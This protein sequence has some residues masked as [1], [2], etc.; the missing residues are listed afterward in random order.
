V[1]ET[2]T[3]DKSV[4]DDMDFESFREAQEEYKTEVQH[5]RVGTARLESC[6]I[7]D[8]SE[9]PQFFK[10]RSYTFSKKYFRFEA[11]LSN[12]DKKVKVICPARDDGINIDTAMKWGGAAEV[13]EL[14]GKRV[15]I[16]HITDDYYILESFS[17]NGGP[18][19]SLL[20]TPAIKSMVDSG[21]LEF[22]SGRWKIPTTVLLSS[23]AIMLSM[24]FVP[25]LIASILPSQILSLTALMTYPA[26]L[27]LFYKMKRQ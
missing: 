1:Q 22:Q 27:F 17:R 8:H 26:T 23:M 21:F 24:A 13:G 7:I 14:A 11:Q 25:L 16:T 20:P 3:S 10:K 2:Q 4:E 15:P 18:N 6:E 19:L 5:G 9:I 12:T